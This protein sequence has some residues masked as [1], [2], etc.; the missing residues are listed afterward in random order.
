MQCPVEFSG[1]YL[2][3]TYRRIIAIGRCPFCQ[4]HRPDLSRHPVRSFFSQGHKHLVLYV[5]VHEL[6]ITPEG[7]WGSIY[8][9]MDGYLTCEQINDALA[10]HHAILREG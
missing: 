8:D 5:G 10:L 1:P 3:E 4:A 9:V 7:G 6:E 2:E